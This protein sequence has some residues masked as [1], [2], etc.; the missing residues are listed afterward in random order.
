[1]KL[2]VAL[3]LVM[4]SA[5]VQAVNVCHQ[6][7]EGIDQGENW[8][9][10]DIPFNFPGT[11]DTQNFLSIDIDNDGDLEEVARFSG[12]TQQ[13]PYL[14]ILNGDKEESF[15]SDRCGG[16]SPSSMNIVSINNKNYI[17]V[18]II[19]GIQKQCGISGYLTEYISGDLFGKELCTI[20]LPKKLINKDK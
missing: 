16:G 7:S 6:I 18:S 12:G 11:R 20:P 15:G 8:V 1:M 19:E 5:S 10:V 3:V 17:H 9:K 13:V 14:E 2:S 4:L